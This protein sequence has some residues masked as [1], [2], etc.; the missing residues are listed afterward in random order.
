MV[1]ETGET[2]NDRNDRAV[3]RAV[4]WYREHLLQSS[5]AVRGRAKKA[6]TIVMLSNDKENLRKARES[7]LDACSCMYELWVGI[8]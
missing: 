8:S 6:P 2:I 3:R 7:N 5:K 4:K 1:R